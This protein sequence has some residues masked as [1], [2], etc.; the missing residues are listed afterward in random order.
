MAKVQDVVKE[1]MRGVFMPGGLM[2]AHGMGFRQSQVT[3]ARHVVALLAESEAGQEPGPLFVEGPT[4]TGKSIGYLVP[5]I[6]HACRTDGRVIV[7]TANIALQEQLVGKDLPMLQNMLPWKF[8]FMLVKGKQ[9]YLCTAKLAK[10]LGKSAQKSFHETNEDVQVRQKLVDWSK[11]TQTGD[12]SELEFNVGQ[13]WQHVSVTSQECTGSACKHFD[14]CWVVKA[15]AGMMKARVLVV[16]YHYLLAMWSVFG[17]SPVE[18][19]VLVCDEAHAMADIARG[20]QAVEFYGGSVK[21]LSNRVRQYVDGSLVEAWELRAAALLDKVGTAIEMYGGE[22]WLNA[23]VSVNPGV[24]DVG[25]VMLA[26]E[27]LRKDL[28]AS[29]AAH[30]DK[31]QKAVMSNLAAICEEWREKMERLGKGSDE[32]NVCWAFNHALGKADGVVRPV[33]KSVPIDVSEF[34]AKHMYRPSVAT[35]VTSATMT[36]GGSF[37]FIVKQL[38]APPTTSAVKLTSPFDMKNQGLLYVPERG[39]LNTS[40]SDKESLEIM[41]DVVRHTGGGV[42]CLFTSYRMLK[43]AA[44]FLGP[45]LAGYERT[46]LV[47]GTLPRTRLLERFR[48]DRDSVLLGTRSFFE[49]VDVA[50]DALE[51]VVIDRLPFPVPTDPVVNAIQSRIAAAGQ[52]GWFGYSLPLACLTIAQAAGRLIRTTTD[53]G[54]VVLLDPRVLTKGYGKTVIKSLP[55][56]PV[57]SDRDRFVKFMAGL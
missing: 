24:L 16:N 34:L 33:I 44:S 11:E 29:A 2:E 9:N 18:N 25:P 5:A 17:E 45:H 22:D 3:M 8:D 28:M 6:E 13:H 1:A 41:L 54:A 7:A 56:F 42:L 52:N 19:T 50:G 35:I 53:R 40:Q 51:C 15:R 30:F 31:E 21:W 47:Q 23:Q 55:P 27:A 43:M 26:C 32:E 20:F 10:W 46:L 37:S 48:D 49:G 36:P 12:R 57:T 38:G 39:P 4:G 14:D